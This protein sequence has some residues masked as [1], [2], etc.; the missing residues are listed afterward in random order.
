M[1]GHS[2]WILVWKTWVSKLLVFS[3]WCM[4]VVLTK[5]F[6]CLWF[7]LFFSKPSTM[8][9]D[10]VLNQ[11]PRSMMN[12]MDDFLPR[13]DGCFK[14]NLPIMLAEIFMWTNIFSSYGYLKR[15]FIFN[16]KSLDPLKLGSWQFLIWIVWTCSFSFS[17]RQ[18]CPMFNGLC[19]NSWRFNI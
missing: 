5:H 11:Q 14:V 6:M 13:C 15:L 3:S 7:M 1:N 17:K 12:S 16:P 9:K 4:F 8:C 10:N 18:W 19:T 2:I